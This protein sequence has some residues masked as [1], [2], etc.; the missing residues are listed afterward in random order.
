MD[1]P[2][3]PSKSQIAGLTGHPDQEKRVTHVPEA[4]RESGQGREAGEN[5]A[6][7][8][9]Q[10]HQESGEGGP[11]RCVERRFRGAVGPKVELTLKPR[12]STRSR[13]LRLSV[14]VT[15][16]AAKSVRSCAEKNAQLL[17]PFT[18]DTPCG[19]HPLDSRLKTLA[20]VSVIMARTV[21]LVAL[22]KDHCYELLHGRSGRSCLPRC[23][24]FSSPRAYLVVIS[25]L[26]ALVLIKY[27]PEGS[28]WVILGAISVYDLMADTTLACFIAILI[29]LC[30]IFLLLAV[31]KKALP[32]RPNSI[33]FGLIFYLSTDHLV[34][35]FMDTL[36][37]HQL[38]I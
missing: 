21:S 38:Y 2:I 6:Q 36:A 27:L 8:R 20:L 28:T 3:C 25:T 15:V 11:D 1:L 9:G 33:T 30:L 7:R 32:A 16:V 31:F 13:H 4:V 22:Y 37:S 17:C 23:C 34:Q 35:P 29:G 14:R 26:T 5:A 12:Q 24:C 10:D 18:E 19:Q